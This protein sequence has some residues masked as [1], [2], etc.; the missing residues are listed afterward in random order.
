TLGEID[1]T[2]ADLPA[3]WTSATR[4]AVQTELAN[5]RRLDRAYQTFSN[6][7]IVRAERQARAADVRGIEAMLAA[8]DQRDAALGR[9][10]PE[11]INALV[12]AVQA[13][14][15]QARQLRLARDHWAMREAAFEKYHLAITE[16][17]DLFALFTRVKP[18][19]EDIKALAGSTPAGLAA[20]E[21][22]V[23]QI[24]K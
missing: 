17:I 23:A 11:A 3:E 5:E 8:V 16:P 6:R 15:D 20:T 14:L 4:T 12:T 24:L 21:R 10:R 9:K 18:A 2:G 7:I 19:L 13:K 1:R 22:L